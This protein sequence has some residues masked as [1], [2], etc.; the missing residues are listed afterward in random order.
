MLPS[1]SKEQIKYHHLFLLKWTKSHSSRERKQAT[2]FSLQLRWTV[3][4]RSWQPLKNMKYWTVFSHPKMELHAYRN[5]LGRKKRLTKRQG[6]V[7]QLTGALLPPNGTVDWTS[8]EFGTLESWMQL[9]FMP[10]SK[11]HSCKSTHL[12]S[13]TSYLPVARSLGERTLILSLFSSIV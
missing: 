8:V 4:W 3:Y 11:C 12:F 9:P 5:L 6:A 10:C 1:F 13:S 7:K 2:L